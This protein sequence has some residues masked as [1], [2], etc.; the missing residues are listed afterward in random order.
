VEA[1]L[2]NSAAIVA[3]PELRLDMQRP[4]I[5]LYGA[6]PFWGTAAQGRGPALEPA[7][8][9]L[10][11]VYQVHDLRQGETISY[12][13]T[14]TAGR[15]MRVAI[16]GAGYADAWSRGLSNR[17]LVLLHGLRAPVVG[18]VCMQMTAVDVTD[19]PQ[20]RAGDRVWLLGGPGENS[21]R[22]EE[23]AQWWGT[24]SYE[25]LCLLGLNRR[26]YIL[27]SPGENE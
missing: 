24:I 26:E 15:D 7:M 6:D 4:G 1:T 3:Y 12:G 11:R 5:A 8:E 21:I 19:V 14:F 27:D 18:R 20:A 16:I 23:L 25:V 9:V 10:T 17:G 13:R 2:A 22:S